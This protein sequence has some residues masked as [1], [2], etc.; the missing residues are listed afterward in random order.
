MY[1]K[2]VGITHL[3]GLQLINW[4]MAK[5]KNK[6][7]KLLQLC[8]VGL[9]IGISQ[10]CASNSNNFKQNQKPDRNSQS[11]S[12]TSTTLLAKSSQNNTEN[13]TDNLGTSLK[14]SI[15]TP[16]KEFL[17]QL[18]PTKRE[19]LNKRWERLR[20]FAESQG[21]KVGPS[22]ALGR[23]IDQLAGTQIP[24]NL[25]ELAKQQN[26]RAREILDNLEQSPGQRFSSCSADAVTFD[27]RDS[28]IV[29]PVRDQ[30]ECG[31]CWAF[32]ALAA[33]E[34]S[35]LYHN[36]LTYSQVGGIVDGSEQHLLNCSGAGS[37]KG[38]WYGPVFDFMIDKGNL[39]ERVFRYQGEEKV[40]RFQRNSPVKAATWGYVSDDGG[41]PSVSEMKQALCKHGPIVSTVHMTDAFNA[42][43]SGVFN[44]NA[45]G[46]PNH[47]ITIIGWDDQKGAWLLKNSWGTDWG[48]DGYMW[49]DYN[50]N[51]I[52]YAAAWV[53][54]RK[55]RIPR[56]NVSS[57]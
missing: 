8:A 55:Y 26:F 37:C 7:S 39:P 41:I 30:G 19:V 34:S 29:T 18:P 31:S 14:T 4:V 53:D 9:L 48:E 23:S 44:E 47:A 28:G 36:N 52:G 38:G 10:A 22:S 2:I 46:S 21:F 51:R 15:P 56:G 20:N 54:A 33:F 17:T 24:A 43:K 1:I 45:F 3:T 42:Y 35:T 13:T 32:A 57:Q 40:C 25:T 50:S 11:T 16:I 5:S 6:Y 12:T 27:W 49:I